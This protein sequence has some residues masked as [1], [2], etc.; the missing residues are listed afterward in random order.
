MT[1]LVGLTKEVFR[2][3]SCGADLKQHVNGKISYIPTL[4]PTAVK[5]DLDNFFGLNDGKS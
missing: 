1:I 3:I 2:C 4:C 5:S